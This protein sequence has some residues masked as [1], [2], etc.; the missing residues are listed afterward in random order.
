MC[1]SGINLSL[2]QAVDP[3]RVQR[4]TLN[5]E[6]LSGTLDCLNTIADLGSFLLRQCDGRVKELTSAVGPR[7]LAPHVEVK[8][9]K[10]SFGEVK[11]FP[12][13]DIYCERYQRACGRT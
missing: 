3:W 7:A 1:S 5:T 13:T 10:H 12:H 11:Q 8:Q 6:T 4:A 2:S 9:V